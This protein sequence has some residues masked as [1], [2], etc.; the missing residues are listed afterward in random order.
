M[1]EKELRSIVL[2]RAIEDA[3][4]GG[5]VLSREERIS[6]SRE[7]RRNVGASLNAEDV[8]A[9]GAGLGRRAERMLVARADGLLARL[10]PRFPFIER[11]LGR[12]AGVT[13]PSRVLLAASVV[14]G[15]ALSA[16]DGTDKIDILAFPLLGVV[17]WNLCVYIAVVV[18]WMRPLRG[19][20]R[21][22]RVPAWVSRISLMLEKRAAGQ[23]KSFVTPLGLA[24]ERFVEEWAEIAKPLITARAARLFHLCAIGVGA[25]LV[26]GLY[27]RGLVLEYE[28]GWESTFLDAGHVRPL[29]T[30]LYGPAS[31]VTGIP[32][33]DVEHL[34]RIR[35]DAGG[36][37]ER[38]APWIH[39]LAVCVVLYVLVPRALLAALS[40]IAMWRWS[41]R[42]HAPSWLPSYFRTLFGGTP[43]LDHGTV[44]VVSYAY[45]AP[46]AALSQ[47]AA[48]LRSALGPEFVVNVREPIPYGEEQTFLGA[49]S[50]DK[51]TAELLVL[52][53]NL[54]ATPEDEN[55]G[56]LISGLRDRLA[57][58]AYRAP[59][60]VLIDEGPYAQRMAAQGGAQERMNERRR[61]WET[62]VRERNVEV[63]FANLTGAPGSTEE[64]RAED[65]AQVER[66]RSALQS[67]GG[68]KS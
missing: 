27:L 55:H 7:A 10:I 61:A 1:R 39:L 13:W 11:V 38:A 68:L 41:L 58:G 49:L 52:L 5:A 8:T 43:A 22:S 20:R 31:F 2:V 35:W 62:F 59:V 37:G 24:L 46:A 44:T 67:A 26:A 17:L 54:A 30:I 32:I 29:L 42:A 4:P 48:L 6:A 14:F 9:R 40:T 56:V 50:G 33:P 25:G 36:G 64:T 19:A 16:L 60:L 15:A 12:K 65:K 34:Q 51:G 45:A 28:A 63:C 21:R 66:L 3:D 53:L 57:S 18:G 47:L 23:S